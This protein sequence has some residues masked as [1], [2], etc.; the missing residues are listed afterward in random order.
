MQ[1]LKGEL[2]L[3]VKPTLKVDPSFQLLASSL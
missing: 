2:Y 1:G 3:C